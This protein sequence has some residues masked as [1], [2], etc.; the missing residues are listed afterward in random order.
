MTNLR[1]VR[2]SVFRPP[3]QMWIVRQVSLIICKAVPIGKGPG[4]V[5][6]GKRTAIESITEVRSIFG[7]KDGVEE[8]V[9]SVNCTVCICEVKSRPRKV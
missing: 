3:Y 4:V 7:Y 2:L 1:R 5:Q 8:N 9:M 6:Q